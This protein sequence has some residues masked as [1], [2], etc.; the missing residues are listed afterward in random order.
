MLAS[1]LPKGG[2]KNILLNIIYHHF[3]FIL[4][5]VNFKSVFKLNFS[6]LEPCLRMHKTSH[7]K[8]GHVP[9]AIRIALFQNIAEIVTSVNFA[10]KSA[11]QTT[12]RKVTKNGVAS[13]ES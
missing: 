2:L 13:R 3:C 9:I 4:L 6:S 5:N 10:V 1:F 7:R 8:M 11:R 12:G